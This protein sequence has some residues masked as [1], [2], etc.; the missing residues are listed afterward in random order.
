M[1]RHIPSVEQTQLALTEIRA[2]GLEDD[3]DTGLM[4]VEHHVHPEGRIC[5][6]VVLAELHYLGPIPLPVPT[7]IIHASQSWDDG[8]AYLD[9]R[10]YE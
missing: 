8:G 7:T 1:V 5:I 2:L 6:T 9:P 4:Q 3:V 10:R